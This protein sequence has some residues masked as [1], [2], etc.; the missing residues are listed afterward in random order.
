MNTGRSSFRTCGMTAALI[1]EVRAVEWRIEF[2]QLHYE[3]GM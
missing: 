1:G 3:E 2:Q